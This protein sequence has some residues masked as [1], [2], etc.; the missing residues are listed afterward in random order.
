LRSNNKNN[1]II[2]R[3]ILESE[4]GCILIIAEE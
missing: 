3:K 2:R 4:T 1:N